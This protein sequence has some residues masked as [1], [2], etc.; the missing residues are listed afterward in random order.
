MQVI[1]KL[2][3]CKYY[4]M[5]HLYGKGFGEECTEYDFIIDFLGL[6]GDADC[7]R[8]FWG[9]GYT[10]WKLTMGCNEY[11]C[12]ISTGHLL[13]ILQAIHQLSF[14]YSMQLYIQNVVTNIGKKCLKWY[15]ICLLK[16]YWQFVLNVMVMLLPS[17]SS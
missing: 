14:W 2:L 1:K 10:S 8:R 11:Q 5:F 9:R 16:L 6:T 13:L 12:H 4:D 17:E 3:F 15:I 7:D